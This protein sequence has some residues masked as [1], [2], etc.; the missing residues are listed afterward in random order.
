[1]ISIGWVFIRF[2]ILQGGTCLGGLVCGEGS[3]VIS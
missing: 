1:M 2:V 3:R